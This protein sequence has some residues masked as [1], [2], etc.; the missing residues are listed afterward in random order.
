MMYGLGKFKLHWELLS[1]AFKIC[2]LSLMYYIL[3][4]G[5]PYKNRGRYVEKFPVRP[6][7]FFLRTMGFRLY[8]RDQHD[9]QDKRH[10]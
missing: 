5:T 7:F 6:V 4:K 10:G 9:R 8:Q 2:L 3:M 1:T